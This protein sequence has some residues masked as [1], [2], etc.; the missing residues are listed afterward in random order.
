MS[1][2]HLRSAAAGI[3]RHLV[4]PVEPAV[5]VAHLERFR[6]AHAPHREY[7]DGCP[8]HHIRTD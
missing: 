5:L 2:D 6:A 3:D 4:K 8:P 1:A 7:G